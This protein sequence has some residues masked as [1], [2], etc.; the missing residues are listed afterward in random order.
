M[1]KAK[2]DQDG[3]KELTPDQKRIA[4]LEAQ[5]KV[6]T[7][8]GKPV[9]ADPK[10]Y[11]FETEEEGEFQFTC[12]KFNM[13]N[14]EYDAAEVVAGAEAE[15]KADKPGPFSEVLAKLVQMKSGIIQPV[16]E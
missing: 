4:Q 7:K 5:L 12:M 8:G 3:A 1:A 6:A 10:D 11:K 16:E 13:D 14:V 9:V 2:K 15:A